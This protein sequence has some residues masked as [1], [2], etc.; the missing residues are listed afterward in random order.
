MA[1]DPDRDP[2][3]D[4]CVTAVRQEPQASWAARMQGQT[5]ILIVHGYNTHFE[6][7]IKE[8]AQVKAGMRWEEGPIVAFSWPSYGDTIQY[9]SDENIYQGSISSFLATLEVLQVGAGMPT[10]LEYVMLA[11]YT[12]IVP[13]FAG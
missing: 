2:G 3:T 4:S 7:A 13:N 6:D 12:V 10:V 9:F 11:Y 8:A 5:V 1:L